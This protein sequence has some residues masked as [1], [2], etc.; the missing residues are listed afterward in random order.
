MFKIKSLKGRE[1]IDSRGEPTVE[2]DCFLEDGS[3]GRASVPSGASR[4]S[5]ESVELRDG[6]ERYQGKS[7]TQ[8]VANVNGIISE[9]IKEKDI[10]QTELDGILCSLDGTENK[11]KLG[12]NAIL[13]VSL[14]FLKA[15]AVSQKKSLYGLTREISGYEG[16]FNIPT[17]MMNIL[18]GGRHAPDSADIQEFMVVPSMSGSFLE[19]LRAGSEIYHTL[20]NILTERNL[21]SSVGDEGGFAPTLKNNEEA[22]QMIL[23]AIKT[24]GYEGK[25]VTIAL[26]AAASEL[27]ENG[28]YNFKREGKELKTEELIS[29]Y[30]NWTEKY[31]IM[32]VEDGL[33]EEDWEGWRRMKEKL[34]NKI[35]VAGDDL[36]ATN[37][38]RLEKGISEKAANA[39]IIKPNQVGTVSETIETVK[40]A[41]KAGY[42]II[43]SHRSG[44]TEDT[45]IVELAVGMGAHYIKAGAPARGERTSKYNQLLRI[46]EELKH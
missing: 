13:S 39:I 6:G 40:T 4:G 31:P 22:V 8:A 2:T 33:Q 1:I 27:Y 29:L 3:V 23:E 26:D 11:G 38:K 5:Y 15:T 9:T 7:V 21:G 20:K 25:E 45:S 35:L 10:N 17:P 14:A 46:E 32:S 28:K 41:K 42:K 36:F 24:A 12:A 16:E 37:V 19:K 30:K 18:N 34:D 44:E 43:F